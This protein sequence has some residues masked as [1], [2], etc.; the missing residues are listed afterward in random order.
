M[1]NKPTVS[2]FI[3]A[4]NEEANIAYLLTSV[5][6]Q[7]EFFYKLENIYVI[8]D[9]S[10]DG[11]VSEVLNI[12][13]NYPLVHLLQDGQR[14][15]KID[16]L[17]QIY[18]LN[19]SNVIVLIDADLYL[20]NPYTIDLLIRKFDDPSV[21]IVGSN[22]K[23]V[24]ARNLL[25]KLINVWF[26]IWY[27]IRKDLDNGDNIHNFSS[28]AFAIKD[29]FAKTLQ[30]PPDIQPITKF[31]YL[32]AVSKKLKV[33][34]APEAVVSFRS[35]DNIYDYLLQLK[36]FSQVNRLNAQYYGDWIYDVSQIPAKKFIVTLL[37]A[38]IVNPL[39]TSASLVFR[40]L[41]SIVPINS[42]NNRI[43]RLAKS[44]KKII[45]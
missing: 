18:Q 35:P 9:N 8:D 5:L 21:V 4:F 24:K 14:R 16:R 28:A 2:I 15:G 29:G 37:K 20:E 43:W 26:C 22:K 34:F 3:P 41:L 40:L 11:T 33:K 44:S 1:N 36:R 42:G 6:K 19:K 31:T 25:E 30:Y 39:Y 13:R 17:N 45:S 10:N 32:A 27:E 38:F 23:P 7:K 12:A